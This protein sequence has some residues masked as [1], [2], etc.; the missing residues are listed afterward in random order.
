MLHGVDDVLLHH[1][2]RDAY[3]LGDLGMRTALYLAH[4]ECLATNRWQFVQRP[5]QQ[6]QLLRLAGLNLWITGVVELFMPQRLERLV[7]AHLRPPVSV[8]TQVD[9]GTKKKR[10]RL[11][12]GSQGLTL[13]QAQ[14][15]FLSHICS[16]LAITKRT[17]EV[18][19]Q[20]LV[21][22]YHDT[23]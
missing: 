22:V 23:L 19:D 4:Q 6:A 20:F 3:D 2:A 13:E 14:D 16:R 1:V 11:L 10:A 17:T 12:D 21:M 5:L 9:R 18:T 7:G 8:D 15:A